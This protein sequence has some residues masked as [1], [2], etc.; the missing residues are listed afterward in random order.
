MHPSHARETP[1]CRG[2][3]FGG[4]PPQSP[5]EAVAR[6]ATWGTE[7]PAS[8]RMFPDV[9]TTTPPHFRTRDVRPLLRGAPFSA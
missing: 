6:F 3:R 5:N 7:V 9:M 8:V 4:L 1:V 2:V